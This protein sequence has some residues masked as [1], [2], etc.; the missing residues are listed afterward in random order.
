M[1][2][3]HTFLLCLLIAVDAGYS[4]QIEAMPTSVVIGL[5]TTLEVKCHTFI[6]ISSQMESLISLI[7]TRSGDGPDKELASI[8]AFSPEGHVVDTSNETLTASGKVDNL[9]ESYLRLTWRNPDVNSRG[10]YVCQALGVSHTGHPVTL[11]S[12]I[13]V[14][15]TYPETDDLLNEI[16]NLTL[17]I[18]FEKE[19]CASNLKTKLDLIKTFMFTVSQPYN[20]HHYLLSNRLYTY[21]VET[22]ETMCELF[23]GY[24][25]EIDSTDEHLFLINFL[26]TESTNVDIITALTGLSDEQHENVWVHKH[27]KTVARYTN[28]LANNPDGGRSENCVVLFQ[29]SWLMV[30]EPCSITRSDF[31]LKL[32]Y[33]CEVPN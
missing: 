21:Q 26:T 22:A 30:D 10:L 23:G 19:Q 3:L 12:T 13:S 27:S 17:E 18:E 14:N 29:P 15:Y 11:T 28:W 8:N 33:L 4:L 9:G 20:G 1:K 16:Q 2:Y 6:N 32:T 25:V 7:I 24:L 31:A 5:T